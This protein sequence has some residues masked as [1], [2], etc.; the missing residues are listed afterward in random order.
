MELENEKNAIKFVK[1][2]DQ[3]AEKKREDERASADGRSCV[4]A[5]P[6]I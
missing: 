1:Y 4:F 3:R 6:D 2:E 5:N